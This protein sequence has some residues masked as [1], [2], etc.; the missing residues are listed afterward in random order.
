MIAKGPRHDS[1][2]LLWLPMT[3]GGKP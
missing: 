3:E 1:Q 2:N